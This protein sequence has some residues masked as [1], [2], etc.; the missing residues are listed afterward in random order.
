MMK[1][2]GSML[3]ILGCTSIGF[4]IVERMRRRLAE[5]EL[6]KRQLL[7]MR[8]EMRSGYQPLAEIFSRLEE[9]MLGEWKSFYGFLREKLSTNR[10]EMLAELW[11]EAISS[12]LKRSLL[13]EEEMRTWNELGENL[14]YL[15]REMQIALLTVCEAHMDEYIEKE[16]DQIKQQAKVYQTLGIMSG[17]FLTM[18][19]V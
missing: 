1:I 7:F 13:D 6:I 5:L 4:Y 10:T 16:K 12:R 8:G 17:I 15:D 18:I 11:G 19:L 9:R 2:I 14:G 3:V